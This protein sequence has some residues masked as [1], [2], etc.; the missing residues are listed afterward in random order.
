MAEAKK[1]KKITSASTGKTVSKEEISANKKMKKA[2]AVPESTTGLRVGAII[3]WVVAL[4][5]EVVALML[6]LGRIHINLGSTLTQ[7]IIA[8]VLDL[9]CV[10]AGSQFWKKANHI[11]PVSEKNKVKFWLW[12]NMGLIVCAFC[13]IPFIIIALTDKNA[14]KKTKT[15]ATVVAVIA[16]L[17]GGLFSVDWNP[18]SEEQKEAA[19]EA[20]ATDVFWSPY[21]HVYHT[22]DD[23]QSLNN[24]DSLTYGSVEEAIAAGRSRLCSFCAKKDNITTVVTDE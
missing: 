2:A 10:I 16:L 24:S 12:N 21:G 8:L 9:A 5:F 17:I 4:G 19:M 1:E 23:C 20:I 3:F 11:N 13:F 6:Y 7:L 14:D 15:V 22:H 18:V